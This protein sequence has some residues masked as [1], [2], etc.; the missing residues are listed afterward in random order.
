MAESRTGPRARARTPFIERL[1]RD[2]QSS[3]PQS[4]TPQIRRAGVDLNGVMSV[5]T[6]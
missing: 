5:G 3:F 4:N 2:M 6:W 1:D